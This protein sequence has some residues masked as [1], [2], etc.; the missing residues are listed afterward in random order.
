MS[1][2]CQNGT[3]PAFGLNFSSLH[4]DQVK[5][6]LGLRKASD[7]FRYIVTPNVDHIVRLSQSPELYNLYENAALLLCDGRIVR[8]LAKFAGVKLDLVS[9]SDM[10]SSMFRDIILPGDTICVI[11]GDATLLQR[12]QARWPDIN[13]H[14][15]VPPMGL[16]TNAKARSEVV[17]FCL[18]QKAR[19][20]F[21]AVGSPQQEIIAGEIATHPDASGTALCIGGAFDYLV[22]IKRRAPLAMQRLGLEFLWRIAEDPGRLWKRYL[23]DGPRILLL[24]ARWL[25]NRRN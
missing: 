17:A 7:R 10:V 3:R 1:V 9:G 2:L 18:S 11:G 16:R 4:Y 8:A 5:T 19:Y 12:M 24:Y 15:M 25:R 6:W 23:L 21:L 20:I 14:Q 13:C 22:G